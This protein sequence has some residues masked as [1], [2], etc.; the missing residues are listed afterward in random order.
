MKYLLN[1]LALIQQPKCHGEWKTHWCLLIVCHPWAQFLDLLFRPNWIKIYGEEYHRSEFVQYGWQP[2]DLPKFGQI[3]DILVVVGSPLLVMEK[4]VTEG[5]NSHL[6][7]YLIV[8]SRQSF[9]L[10]LSTLLN[11]HVLCGHN[12]IGD[13]LLYIAMR[14]HACW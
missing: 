7:S 9:V 1:F 12:Y 2:D 11:P 14:S 3:T 10:K 5:I 4:Y 6:L 13:G 8:R